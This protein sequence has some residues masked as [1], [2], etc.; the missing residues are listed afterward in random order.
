MRGRNYRVREL[1]EVTTVLIT[2]IVT[3]TSSPLS[4]VLLFAVSVT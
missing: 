4:A 3:P 1:S 2:V